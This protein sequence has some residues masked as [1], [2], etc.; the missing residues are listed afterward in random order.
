MSSC[1]LYNMNSK[2]IEWFY[3]AK[4]SKL[5]LYLNP[6]SLKIVINDNKIK[7]FN[8]SFLTFATDS[9]TL[10]N[11]HDPHCQPWHNVP[12][13]ISPN[14]IVLHDPD[15]WEYLVEK[16]QE[17]VLG[18]LAFPAGLKEAFPE[19]GLGSGSGTEPL[20]KL[21]LGKHRPLD[22]HFGV[23]VGL[24]VQQWL[25][26][27]HIFGTHLPFTFKSKNFENIWNQLQNCVSKKSW[28]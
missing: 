23:S 28:R 25:P 19:C 4:E 3:V 12:G 20:V 5:H 7:P 22:D 10:R 27:L 16:S 26:R 9:L 11:V 18:T 1:Y 24:S 6:N 8:L 14:V 17:A 15:E 13:Q 2:C 21:L